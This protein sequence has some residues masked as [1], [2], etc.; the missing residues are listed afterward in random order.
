MFTPELWHVSAGGT[1]ATVFPQTGMALVTRDYFVFDFT[2]KKYFLLN[3]RPH[4][5]PE[6]DKLEIFF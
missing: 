5:V 2:G 1:L 6:L 3:Y 4:L